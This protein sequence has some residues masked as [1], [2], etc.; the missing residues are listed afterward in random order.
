MSFQLQ[1]DVDSAT[2]GEL[3]AL[4]SAARA[5]GVRDDD[6]LELDGTT[7]T[8]AVSAPQT[9]ASRAGQNVDAPQRADD[10]EREGSADSRSRGRGDR[11]GEATIRSLIDILNERGTGNSSRG[12]GYGFFGGSS[13]YHG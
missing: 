3:A 4:L 5:A 9:G 11:I 7:L 12:N 6:V 2:V 13:D 10:F 8:I 1:L